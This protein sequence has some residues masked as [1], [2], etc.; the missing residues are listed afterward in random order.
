MSD[1][2]MPS[3]VVAEAAETTMEKLA[4]AV[5]AVGVLESVTRTVKVDVPVVLGV[6]E[7]TPADESESPVGSEPDATAQ[8]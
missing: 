7:I 8:A 5:L 4:V 6:P 1:T 3:R 2:K